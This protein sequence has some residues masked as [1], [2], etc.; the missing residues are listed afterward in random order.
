MSKLKGPTKIVHRDSTDGQ[1]VT[2][3]YA[4]NH[5]DTTEKERVHIK[6]PEPPKKR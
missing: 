2:E 1:F 5:P 6:P 3:R 4:E